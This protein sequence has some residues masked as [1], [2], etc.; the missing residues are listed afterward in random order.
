MLLV[1]H[2]IAIGSYAV[3]FIDIQN[4]IGGNALGGEVCKQVGLFV[5]GG[6][7]KA[8][9]RLPCTRNKTLDS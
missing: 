7:L 2:H 9:Q 3:T 4:A 1:S 8:S 6:D 5:E